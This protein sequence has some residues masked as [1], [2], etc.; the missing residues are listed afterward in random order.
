MAKS[1]PNPLA[2]TAYPSSSP[3]PPSPPISQRTLPIA[4]LLCAIYGLSELPPSTSSLACLWLLHPR[5]QSQE[6]MAPI[7]ASILHDYNKSRTKG[8]G[9]KG[10]KG[11]IAISFDQRNHGSR[12]VDALANESWRGGNERHAVDMWGIYSQ[13]CSAILCDA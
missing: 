7:A 1:A 3:S 4:G 6:C 5:L 13:F 10:Q 12:L 2:D 8:P 11:L 9:G